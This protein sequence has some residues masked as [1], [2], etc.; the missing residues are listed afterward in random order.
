MIL[1][2]IFT[3]QEMIRGFE[4]DFM[5]NKNRKRRLSDHEF[6]STCLRALLAHSCTKE[7]IGE[8]IRLDITGV[9]RAV[10]EKYNENEELMVYVVKTLANLSFDPSTIQPI[11]NSGNQNNIN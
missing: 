7:R 4:T 6:I 9:L 2:T 5:G 11:Y 10:V 3:F 8:L 1:R